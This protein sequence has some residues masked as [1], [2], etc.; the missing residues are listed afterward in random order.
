M[1]DVCDAIRTAGTLFAAA[2]AQPVARAFTG[3]GAAYVMNDWVVRHYRRGGLI[4]KLSHDAYVRA[5]TPRPFCELHASVAARRKHV[6]TPEVVAAIVYPG[7]ATYR[8]D[9][10]TR[11]IPDSRSLADIAIR[12]QRADAPLRIEAWRAAGS[13]LRIAFDAGVHHADLNLGNILIAGGRA[14]LIDLDRAH[15]S[16]GAVGASQRAAMIARFHRSRRKLE[17]AAH[18]ETPP[19]E[20]AA[21]EQSLHGA[22]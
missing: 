7:V 3:R 10:A 17:A 16:D 4:A 6:P 12:A 2:A 8:G 9:I 13:L 14:L 5:G 19:D 15:V 18:F 21:F 22:A 20:L 1:R 11:L